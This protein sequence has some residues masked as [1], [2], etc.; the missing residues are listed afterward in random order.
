MRN[1]VWAILNTAELFTLVS[2]T[3]K[4]VLVHVT[5]AL[6]YCKNIMQVTRIFSVFQ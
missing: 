5:V 3:I 1:V 6:L 4:A 2:V